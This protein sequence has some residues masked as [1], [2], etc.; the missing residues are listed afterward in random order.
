MPKRATID[1]SEQVKSSGNNLPSRLVAHGVEGVGKTEFAANAPGA[2]TI[3]TRGETGLET[4]IDNGRVRDT[5]HFPETME[6]DSLLSQIEWLTDAEHNYKTAVIDT[7]NGAERLCHEHVCKRDF[8]NNWGKDGF[9]SFQQGYDAALGDWRELLGA[10]DRLR[11]TRRMAIICLCHTRV[12]TFKNPE[13]ADYDRYVPDMHH[14]TW[15]L[16]HKWADH[17][18]FA[19][20]YTSVV[21]GKAGDSELSS[22]KGKG[23]GG[24]DRVMYTVRHAAYDAKNRAG[25]PEEISMGSS[26]EEA[27]NN[28]IAELQKA[29]AAG[30]VGE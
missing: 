3:M 7:L 5:P 8:R 2:I 24:Q 16:T 20:F 22:G 4:L 14:K 19:N 12:A 26:G 10:L 11:E 1:W 25:L 13:G 15:S 30:K 17:V 27:W 6:W 9:T 29:K 18:L 21:G 28:F 23:R